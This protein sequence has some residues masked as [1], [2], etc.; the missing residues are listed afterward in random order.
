MQEGLL[1]F[2]QDSLGEI[3]EN[4]SQNI[5]HNSNIDNTCL[6]ELMLKSRNKTDIFELLES[7]RKRSLDIFEKL[8]NS[9]LDP[10]I[11]WK[12]KSSDPNSGFYKKLEEFNL[13]TI[14]LKLINYYDT[15]NDEYSIALKLCEINS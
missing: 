13:E 9:V 7:E 11:Q 10:M 2:P 6:I 5:S 15:E 8:H 3:I 4:F 1:T 12:K 14:T